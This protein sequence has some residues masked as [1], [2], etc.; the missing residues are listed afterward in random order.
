MSPSQGFDSLR[1]GLG[2]RKVLKSLAAKSRTAGGLL[3]EA[4]SNWMEDNAPSL[5][6]ALA[7]YTIFSL[8]PVLIV[9]T[10]VASLV[11]ER[12]VVQ[13]EILQQIEAL[14][15]HGGAAAVQ[16]VLHSM[17]RPVVR[18]LASVVGI[19]IVLVGASGAFVELQGALNKIWK[20]KPREESFW[21]CALKSRCSSFGLV[22]GTGLLLVVSLAL[23]AA[24]E[25]MATFMGHLL[26]SARF[27]LLESANF[28]VSTAIIMLL[29]AMIYKVLPDTP[30][31][32]SDVWIGAG[33]TAF[34]FSVGKF[35]IGLYLGRSTMASAYG[36]AGSLVILLVW[37]Y[38]S[39]Q[40][41]LLGAEF[42][43]VYAGKHGSRAGLALPPPV[44]TVA[45]AHQA[46]RSAVAGA[47]GTRGSP[48]HESSVSRVRQNGP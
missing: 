9:T 46:V 1:I 19:A 18:T 44:G 14:V 48:P 29:F 8:A 45:I 35:L 24:L 5:G 13:G 23:S 33:A 28:I 41:L 10:A 2:P 21:V 47:S 32:W 31:A 30:I 43:H 38:Y 6:A 40:L 7:F 39:A 27:L 34:F 26:P 22:L 25:A 3:K 12:R 15:G 37:V 11:F 17:N 36:A 16:S 4:S 42:T 20:V